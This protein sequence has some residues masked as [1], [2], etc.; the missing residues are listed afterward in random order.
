MNDLELVV[1]LAREAGALAGGF[2]RT[3][4]E[5]RYKSSPSDVVSDA[6]TQ[7]EALIRQILSE[8][9]PEDGMLGEE[10]TSTTGKRRWLVDAVDGTFN[11]LK[12]DPFWCTALALED[13]DG[14]VVSAVHHVASGETFSAARGQGAWLNGAQLGRSAVTLDHAALAT[15]LHPGDGEKATYQRVLGS[16]A[17]SRIRG[18]GS[19]ELAWL[20]AGR[21]DVWLQRNVLPWDWA[22]GSLLVTEAGG[23]SASVENP[24]GLWSFAADAASAEE[25]RQLITGQAR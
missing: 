4:L 1:R 11:F 5:V 7:A 22:P 10:G 9:R 18:S 12:G 13:A 21:I 6:D 23:V 8:E 24:E 3:G 15:Y 19:L 20:A 17:T 2:F 14:V 25:L 16:V